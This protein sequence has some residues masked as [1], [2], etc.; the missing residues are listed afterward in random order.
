MCDEADMAGTTTRTIRE[1]HNNPRG[2]N[3]GY[4]FNDSS[5]GKVDRRALAEFRRLTERAVS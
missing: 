3:A 4:W 2:E 5:T 1:L